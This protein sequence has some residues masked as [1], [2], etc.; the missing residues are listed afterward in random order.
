[1]REHIQDG[2]NAGYKSPFI[3]ATTDLDVALKFAGISKMIVC[4]KAEGLK[5]TPLSTDFDRRIGL[6]SE[7]DRTA[8]QTLAFKYSTRSSEVLIHTRV[9]AL[10]CTP[11]K[12]NLSIKRVVPSVEKDEERWKTVA[13]YIE[14]NYSE[15]IFPLSAEERANS[16][17]SEIKVF[18]GSELRALLMKQARPNRNFPLLAQ[19][20]EL[21]QTIYKEFLAIQ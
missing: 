17:F 3:S 5:Y 18:S 19:F 21:L 8:E 2:S 16:S 9:P 12:R 14:E 10:S 20:P 13:K 15:G 11:L 4:I 6:P 7:A 1:M